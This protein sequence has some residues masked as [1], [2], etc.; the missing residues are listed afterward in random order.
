[1]GLVAVIQK[2]GLIGIIKATKYP[3]RNVQGSVQGAPSTLFTDEHHGIFGGTRAGA[4]SSFDE[5]ELP[6]N[7]PRS[8]GLHWEEPSIPDPMETD[9]DYDPE[10]WDDRASSQG[11]DLSEDEMRDSRE[12]MLHSQLQQVKDRYHEVQTS[13]REAMDRQ[14]SLGNIRG[15]FLMTNRGRQAINRKTGLTNGMTTKLNH[16]L[17]DKEQAEKK[18]NDYLTWRAR[19][20]IVVDE[21]PDEQTVREADSPLEP[22]NIG[23]APK[24][25]PSPLSRIRRLPTTRGGPRPGK[26]RRRDPDE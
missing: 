10:D 25:K 18:Y 1:M 5:D 3:L 23:V 21:K 17:R 15:R 7:D 11:W 13:M 20:K 6:V 19:E 14:E 9:E 26:K 8:E 22:A 2:Q 4:P 16:M 24:K 12:N